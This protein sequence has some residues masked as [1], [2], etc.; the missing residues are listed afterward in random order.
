MLRASRE[1]YS[2]LSLMVMADAR[3][4]GVELIPSVLLEAE[5]DEH[6]F[7]DLYCPI[8]SLIVVAAYPKIIACDVVKSLGRVVKNG[9]LMV[10]GEADLAAMTHLL[11]ET[12]AVVAE[13]LPA[14]FAELQ[15]E[16]EID[17]VDEECLGE[18]SHGLPSLEAHHVACRDGVGDV[19]CARGV[20]RVLA[21]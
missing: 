1:A 16:V 18:A 20:L 11:I 17:A 19:F 4:H 14:C 10:E 21:P 9:Y 7:G 12:D 5:D 6:T 2:H 8:E 13:D 3:K 15:A